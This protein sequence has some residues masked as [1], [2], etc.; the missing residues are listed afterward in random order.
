MTRERISFTF[1]PRDMLLSLQMGFTFVRAAVACAVLERTSGLKPS[2]ETTATRYLK[3]VTVP[4]L[5]L[6][7][8]ISLLMQL[9]LFVISLVF[10]ALIS[11]L[12]VEQV[13]SRLSTRASSSC[14]SS[15]RAS[16]LSANRRLVIF[17]QPM[18]TFPSC[19]S[20]ASDMIRSRKMLKW[21]VTEDILALLRLL[22]SRFCYRSVLKHLS[23]SP[24]QLEQVLLVY[25]LRQ[26]SPFSVMLL[27]SQLPHGGLVADLLLGA[28]CNP[29]QCGLHNS[30]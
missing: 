19:S 30:Q 9:A 12:Y 27:Q 29:V 13:L 25:Q 1:D 20:R 23:W 3:L 16:M 21:W 5:C 17:L 6:F 2:S 15:A 28:G 4:N 8:F 18:L 24:R 26:T 14:S 22:F 11:I 10:S 7:T